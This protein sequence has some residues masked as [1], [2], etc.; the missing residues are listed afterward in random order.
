MI[1]SKKHKM[2]FPRI[3][4]T[5]STSITRNIR[6]AGVLGTTDI[7]AKLTI[8]DAASKNVN[9]NMGAVGIA[10]REGDIRFSHA[11]LTTALDGGLLTQNDLDT[12]RVRTFIRHPLTRFLS[13]W[14]HLH[15]RKLAPN[16]IAMFVERGFFIGNR[17][18]NE[19][20]VSWT[21][22][23]GVLSSEL[24]FFEDYA[25]ELQGV[26]TDLGKPD[27]TVV[28]YNTHPIGNNI[29]YNPDTHLTLPTKLELRDF[30]ADDLQMWHTL[31]DQKG[32]TGNRWE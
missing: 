12:M 13:G 4:K 22:I 7:A 18:F 27:Y 14:R 8:A 32:Y 31:A 2:I 6:E 1:I 26:M 3:P 16:H 15:R 10:E 5:G 17:I 9:L 30:Y 29:E 25:N 20:Q 19:P 28:R 24:L 11:T 21:H 23:D